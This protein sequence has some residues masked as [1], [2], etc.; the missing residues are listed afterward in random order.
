MTLGEG[1]REWELFVSFFIIMADKSFQH[2]KM[3]C[4]FL[5]YLLS[6][7]QNRQETHQLE[8]VLPKKGRLTL[9][10]Q[11]NKVVGLQVGLSRGNRLQYE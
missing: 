4:R 6:I 11:E 3:S 5:P 10:S 9:I 8:I 7:T 1:E 2:P